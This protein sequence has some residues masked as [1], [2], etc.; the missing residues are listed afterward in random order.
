[1]GKGGSSFPCF[2]LPQEHSHS[3]TSVAPDGQA[4]LSPHQPL[5]GDSWGLE[6]SINEG[7]HL[8]ADAAVGNWPGQE[9]VVGAGCLQQEVGV[10]WE[11]WCT[12][13]SGI[14]EQSQRGEE[15]I[16]AFLLDLLGLL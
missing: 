9:A 6:F 10:W 2:S 13:D 11:V 3:G 1:M 15:V 7:E 5:V 4:L 12:E 14:E 8:S 16:G